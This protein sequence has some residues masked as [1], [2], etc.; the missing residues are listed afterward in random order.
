VFYVKDVF[1]M[2]ID[3]KM[4]L[5]QIRESLLAALQDPNAR[6]KAEKKIPVKAAAA[7]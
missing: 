5:K 3:H 4:K 2:K 7:E 1:G 6:K